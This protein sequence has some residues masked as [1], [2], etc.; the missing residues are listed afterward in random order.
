MRRIE[1]VSLGLEVDEAEWP[2]VVA[3]WHGT[4]SEQEF[5]QTFALMDA[6]LA[7]EERFG[8]L[9]D[10]RGGGGY[11]PEQRAELIRYM[12]AHAA[13]TERL[14]IQAVVMDNLIM[15]TLFYGINVVF[16]NRF[17]SKV[18]ADPSE[19]RAW[20]LSMLSGKKDE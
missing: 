11:S 16:P 10:A 1:G 13:Q 17:P 20:L 19:A 9:I 8:L 7:R 5:T 3:R 4:T 12:K 14:L 6:W 18:F 2:L 15:R